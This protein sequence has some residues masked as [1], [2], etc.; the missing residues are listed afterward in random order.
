MDSMRKTALVAGLFYLI[1]F[2]SIP[3]LALYAPV[4]TH[5]DFIISAG[6]TTPILVGGF[7]EMIVALAGI[8]TAVALFSVVKRQ[9]EGFALGFVTTRIFEAAVIAIGVMSILSVVTLQQPGATGAEATSLV[10]VGGALVATYNWTFL[11]GQSLMPGL[12]ALMVGT[13]MYRSGLVPR[14]IPA[15]GLIGAPLLITATVATL[16]GVIEQ[17]S[18]L[19][20]LAAVPIGVWELSLGLWLTFKG[21]RPA[22]VAALTADSTNGNQSA[23]AAAPATIATQAGAA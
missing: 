5:P 13:L 11:L 6:A 8:G 7:L 16:F 9:H 15:L 17:Y 19:G 22:A 21:F 4:K 14:A 12:N 20:T 18:A 10:T 23:P 3:T 1:T 2:V